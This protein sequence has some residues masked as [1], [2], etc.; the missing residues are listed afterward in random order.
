MLLCCHKPPRETQNLHINI[1]TQSLDTSLHSI[2]DVFSGQSDSVHQVA[3]IVHH[4]W[5]LGLMDRVIV[6]SNAKVAFGQ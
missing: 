6:I 1:S 5:N 4:L 3:I 2:K